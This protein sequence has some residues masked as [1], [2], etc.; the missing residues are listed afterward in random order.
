MVATKK[1]PSRKR[2]PT[3]KVA[4]GADES[5]SDFN[6]ERVAEVQEI[7]P[8][9]EALVIR[10]DGNVFRCHPDDIGITLDEQDSAE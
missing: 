8:G 2:P 4:T 7:T 9:K 3:T 6:D 1:A 5:V 10:A